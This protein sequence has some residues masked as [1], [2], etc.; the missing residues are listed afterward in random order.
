MNEI[1][2]SESTDGLMPEMLEGFFDGWPRK[3]VPDVLL[4][5]LKNSG[6]CVMALDADNVVGFVT[7]ITD[8]VL[9]AYIPLLEVLPSYKGNG[10]GSELVNRLLKKLKNFYMI[11]LSCDPGLQPFYEG[12][13]MKKA[14]GMS[15]RNFDRQSG[16]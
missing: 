15:I 1:H 11:D 2:Y 16:K 8:G 10:I 12:L 4:R 14:T 6:Y 13:G 5:L 3:P 7:A 9:A